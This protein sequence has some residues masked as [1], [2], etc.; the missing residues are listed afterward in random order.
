M[1][2][3]TEHGAKGAVSSFSSTAGECGHIAC[4]CLRSYGICR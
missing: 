4:C 2:E 3:E 1:S